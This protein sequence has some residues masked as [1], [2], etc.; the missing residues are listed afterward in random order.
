[1]GAALT[2]GFRGGGGV[3][4]GDLFR[5]GLDFSGEPAEGAGA[6]FV[7]GN[8]LAVVAGGFNGEEGAGESVGF[9]GGL[10]E[11]KGGVLSA[12]VG[13]VES[14]FDGRSGTGVVEG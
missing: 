5:K 13:A 6:G 4:S 7:E 1:L 12:G 11:D 14:G 10:W 3:L 2:G 8:G 9:N